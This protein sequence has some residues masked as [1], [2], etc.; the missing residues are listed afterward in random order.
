MIT[1]NRIEKTYVKIMLNL[2]VA[3]D[4]RIEVCYDAI[5]AKKGLKK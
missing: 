4:K 1:K 2:L 3:L 5:N